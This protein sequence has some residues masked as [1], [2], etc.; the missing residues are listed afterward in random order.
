[1]SAFRTCPT[2]PGQPAIHCA[3]PAGE[4]QSPEDF[5]RAVVAAWA[6]IT[7]PKG[8]RPCHVTD[9]AARDDLAG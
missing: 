2:H 4:A 1:M 6:A 8:E 3:C 9:R 7:R 5:A